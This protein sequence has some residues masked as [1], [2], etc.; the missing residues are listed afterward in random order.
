MILKESPW[1]LLQQIV[2]CIGT[3]WTEVQ[4]R[5]RNQIDVIFFGKMK[6]YKYKMDLIFENEIDR[7]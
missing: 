7:I 4:Y 2:L 3:F 5:F 1:D 6:E